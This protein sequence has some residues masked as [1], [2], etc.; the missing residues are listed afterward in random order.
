[1][2]RKKTMGPVVALAMVAAFFPVTPHPAHALTYLSVSQTPDP[3]EALENTGNP[4]SGTLTITNS[5]RGTIGI[6]TIVF[7]NI[8]RTGGDPDDMATN[9]V[10]LAPNPT[11]LNP[12]LLQ[13]GKHFDI[14]FHWDAVDT[15]GVNDFD[16]GD[17]H[18]NIILLC[19]V[20]CSPSGGGS[21]NDSVFALLRVNDPPAVP[22]PPPSLLFATG[23]GA[24][25]LFG[26][27]RKRK[28]A[29]ALAAA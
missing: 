2:P 7:D 10:I 18:F 1:M 13:P 21:M 4:Q 19:T 3:F 8:S 5:S 29:A 6:S 15:S 9:G 28:N 17:W 11:I 14:T 16:H 20:I 12:I 22:L 24:L 23:L 27:R 25:G 26:W